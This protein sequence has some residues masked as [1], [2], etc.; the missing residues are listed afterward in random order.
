M[1]LL[2]PPHEQ[3]GWIF[4]KQICVLCVGERKVLGTGGGEGGSEIGSSIVLHRMEYLDR[5]PL[6]VLGL[7]SGYFRGRTQLPSLP[8]KSVEY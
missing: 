6:S 5:R 7:A 3:P 4:L 2:F 1:S 8:R